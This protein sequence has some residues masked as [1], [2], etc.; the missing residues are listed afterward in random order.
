MDE[1][2]GA[3]EGVMERHPSDAVAATGR[4]ELL[5][6]MKRWKAAQQAYRQ[7][8]ERFPWDEVTRNGY[9]WLL[10]QMGQVEAAFELLPETPKSY[11][12]WIALN[13]RGLLH[14]QAKRRLE[15]RTW[16]EKAAHSPFFEV[17]Q[18]S[19]ALLSLVQLCDPEC[20][21]AT[22]VLKAS[23]AG[24]DMGR[25]MAMYRDFLLR[26]KVA[27]ARRLVV[28]VSQEVRAVYERLS[29]FFDADEP[30]NAAQVVMVMIHF[31]GDL[32]MQPGGRRW[33]AQ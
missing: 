22:V 25:I 30:M 31:M 4:A 19:E 26:D 28:G 17:A 18:R 13:I 23:E 32:L 21:P 2:L 20:D 7:A 16:F 14:L 6:K 33:A 27:A 10:G 3:Y 8:Y 1:A 12:D 11:E 15:A 24:S 29:A 5:K 9:A